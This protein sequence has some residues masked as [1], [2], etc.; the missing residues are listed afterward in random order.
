MG[1]DGSDPDQLTDTPA[2]GNQHPQWSPDGRWIVFDSW[3]NDGEASSDIWMIAADGRAERRI[4]SDAAMEEY[5]EWSPD[6]TRILFTVGNA[7]LFTMAADGTDRRR[8]TEDHFFTAGDD[9]GVDPTTGRR[10]P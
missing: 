6:G 5:P 4:T 8:V 2:G 3:R 10:D 7:A 1:A 9:W